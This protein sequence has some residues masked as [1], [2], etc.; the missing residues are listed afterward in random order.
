MIDAMKIFNPIDYAGTATQYYNKDYANGFYTLLN[1]N[2]EFSI[3]RQNFTSIVKDNTGTKVVLTA[4]QSFCPGVSIEF[5]FN[6]SYGYFTFKIGDRTDFTSQ[7]WSIGTSS[8]PA[9]IKTIKTKNGGFGFW[10]TTAPE[11]FF[12]I[13]YLSNTE[14]NAILKQ[15]LVLDNKQPKITSLNID[16]QIILQAL[17]SPDEPSMTVSSNRLDFRGYNLTKGGLTYFIYP[18]YYQK[19]DFLDVYYYDGGASFI[20]DK[21][22][23]ILDDRIFLCLTPDSNLLIEL[24]GDEDE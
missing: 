1:E 17:I 2:E 20:G 13:N 16:Y 3:L 23:T 7:D 15:L 11:T 4:D 18:F 9:K 19:Y 24:K 6:S 21:E 22:I 12:I 5:K 10:F 8:N 14:N